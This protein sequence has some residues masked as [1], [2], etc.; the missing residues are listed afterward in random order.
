MKV[1]KIE[2]DVKNVVKLQSAELPGNMSM[3][4]WFLCLRDRD[5]TW[6][7]YRLY[8]SLHILTRAIFVAFWQKKRVVWNLASVQVH[9]RISVCPQHWILAHR[10]TVKT[11]IELGRPEVEPNIVKFVRFLAIKWNLE[12]LQTELIPTLEAVTVISSIF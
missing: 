7:L 11:H 5:Q 12:S 8:V 2:R 10:S 9:N 1:W 3:S 6:L 4:S